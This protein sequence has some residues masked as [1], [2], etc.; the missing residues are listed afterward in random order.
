MSKK[1]QICCS[2]KW[3][4]TRR[5]MNSFIAQELPPIDELVILAGICMIIAIV[6]IW[7]RLNN[8]AKV[9][10]TANDIKYKEPCPTCGEPLRGDSSYCARCGFRREDGPPTKPAV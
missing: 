6:L 3:A 9:G 5:S 8:S 1:Q 7:R 2:N 4:L 10:Q